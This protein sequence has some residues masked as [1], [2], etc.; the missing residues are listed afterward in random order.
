MQRIQLIH[1]TDLYIWT[2]QCEEALKQL[3]D[4]LMKSPTLVYPDPKEPYTSFTDASKY[5][6][7]EYQHMNISLSLVIKL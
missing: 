6:W 7:S 1:K 3:R 5:A 2:D 4:A